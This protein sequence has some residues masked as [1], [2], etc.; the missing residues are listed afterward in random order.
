MKS[1]FQKIRMFLKRKNQKFDSPPKVSNL[2]NGKCVCET[3]CNEYC[4]QKENRIV[5]IVWTDKKGNSIDEKINELSKKEFP[6]YSLINS[7]KAEKA[8]FKIEKKCSTKNN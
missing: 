2:M 4:S 3:P 7:L 8:M 1:R 5:K 6:N